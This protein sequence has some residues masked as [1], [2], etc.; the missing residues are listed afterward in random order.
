LGDLKAASAVREAD[1]DEGEIGTLLRLFQR[2]T[3]ADGVAD[4]LEASIYERNLHFD[5]EQKVVLD[6]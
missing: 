5:R 3:H 1:V 4:N 6:N 2:R